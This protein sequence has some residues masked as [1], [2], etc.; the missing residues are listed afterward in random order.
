M[1]RWTSSLCCCLSVWF[2]CTSLLC[3]ESIFFKV[4]F[5]VVIFF[6]YFDAVG[7]ETGR[8]IWLVR[9]LLQ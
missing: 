7:W 3:H 2:S 5:F 6:Q 9:N 1:V 8:A 4:S